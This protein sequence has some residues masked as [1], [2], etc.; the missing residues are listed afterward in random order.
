[1][2][3]A[4]A[5]NHAGTALQDGLFLSLVV[6]VSLVF[7]LPRLG[8][9]SDDWVFLA[10]LHLS[11]DHSLSG[12]YHALY[13]GD[14]VIRQRPI[15]M[16]YLVFFYWCF[17]LRP[18]FY[19][20]ANALALMANGILL[21]LV[22]RKFGQARFVALSISLVYLLLPHYSTDRF[23]VAAHQATF[24][25]SFYLLSLYADL[26]AFQAYPRHWMGWKMLSLAGLVLSCLSYEVALPLFFLNPLFVWLGSP[27]KYR[28]DVNGQ[29]GWI[30]FLSFFAPNLLVLT[31][32]VGFKALVT[33]RTNV[34][35][36]I[37]AHLLYIVTG[38]LR[39]NF[40]TYGLGLPY[41]VSWILF[42]RPNWLMVTAG[43]LLGLFTFKY[44]YSLTR[45]NA[46]PEKKKWLAF[47]FLGVVVFG[48]GYAIFVFNAD[49]WFTS[50]SLGNRVAIAAAMGVAILI[51]GMAGWLSSLIPPE[52][53]RA[54]F[55]LFP[56]L[57]VTSG[58]LIINTLASFWITAYQGQQQILGK[59]LED[60]PTLPSGSTLILD[61][62]CL[63]RGGAYLFTGTRD[64]ASALW[65][66]YGDKSLNA[67][68]LSN[69][70]QIEEQGLFIQTYNHNDFYP[71]GKDLLV[72]DFSGE[73]VYPLRNVKMARQYFEQTGFIPEEDC[74]PGFAW[75]WNNQ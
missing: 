18:I 58:F 44:L 20:I 26:K 27:Q 8:F 35:T 57:L 34:N 7:Y 42:H 23:W 46:F 9:Y 31:L 39:V 52:W 19:H 3:R 12:L 70:P 61:D 54:V 71:Y 50:A 59:M 40:V 62:V 53:A 48:A 65:L 29:R 1:V 47:I 11:P 67:T 63:E 64:L 56:S 69:S 38:A 30:K 68:V 28:E 33:V 36:D 22:V 37:L 15:Q 10:I 51:I 45:E 16:V 24:S 41:I 73:K 13:D 32:V 21:Y 75:G 43:C 60:L 25:I 49:V 74:P 6:L 14:V 5:A 66:A 72:Y 55:C 4:Y 2:G 17:G